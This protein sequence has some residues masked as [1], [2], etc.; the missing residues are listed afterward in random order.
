MK[1]NEFEFIFVND[2]SKGNILSLIKDL[3]VTKN[4]FRPCALAQ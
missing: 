2:E 4:R 1:D 3:T